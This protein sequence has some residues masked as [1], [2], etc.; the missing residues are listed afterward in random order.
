[1]AVSLTSI[2]QLP[3]LQFNYDFE[4]FF[5]KNDP[6][7]LAYQ[8]HIAEFGHD[9]DYLLIAVEH[10]NGIFNPSFL[11]KA[12][13]MIRHISALE[14]VTQILSPLSAQ[15]IIQS[16]LGT[17]LV[18]YLHKDDRNRLIQDSLQLSS[19]PNLAEKLI[20]SEIGALA[21][22]VYHERY[23]DKT[24]EAE[25]SEAI[26]QVVGDF[27]FSNFHVAGRIQA[28]SIFVQLI[29]ENF[30]TFLTISI[31]LIIS[32]LFLLFGHLKWVIIP[33]VMIGLSIAISLSVL[34]I[35]N[36][37]VDILSSMLPTILLVTAMS[38]ITHF[39]TRYFDL[40]AR[41]HDKLEA[42]RLTLKEVGMATFLTSITTAIGFASLVITDS[43]PVRNLGIYTSIG[44]MITYAV[45]FSLLS[46]TATLSRAPKP[47]TYYPI[48]NYVLGKFFLVTLRHSKQVLV[49]YG[50]LTLIAFAGLKLLVVDTPLIAD[51]PRDHPVTYDFAFFD[52]HFGGSKPLEVS[53]TVN[54]P[55]QDML[56]PD[57]IKAV[58]KV[59]SYL[60]VPFPNIISPADMVKTLNM[61]NH[62]GQANYYHL[63]DSQDEAKIAR[64]FPQ[65][66]HHFPIMLI[67]DDQQGGRI[68]GFGQDLGSKAGLKNQQDF[69]QYVSSNIN[70]DL[71][72][73][74]FT[75]T[76][77]LF[78]LTTEA[79][80]ENIIF[81]LA[82][83]MAVVALIMSLLFRSLKMILI[84][85]LPNILPLL[86]LAA[87]M[88]FFGIPLRLSTSIIF[89]IAFGIAV[90]DTIHFLTRFNLEM[91]RAHDHTKH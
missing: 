33:L 5:E 72:G 48:W 55:E 91:K 3:G 63:P 30:S 79:L 11:H 87:V 17:V 36:Q 21:F 73:F 35:A 69:E 53:I 31:V 49:V 20:N 58:D 65:L 61:A 85:L 24:L 14:G 13:S 38:D 60:G 16:P 25:L 26:S 23:N 8:D 18:P 74:K 39:L 15:K 88:A 6:D 86:F 70:N 27:A 52:Q 12:D 59:T 81:G 7:W 37:A 68:T 44:V 54:D 41:G 32:I 62:G 83:A 43:I 56:S 29:R 50:I 46:A 64:Q 34:V 10:S 1:M 28:Q 42:V 9:N 40:T 77:Y 57:V 67:T 19:H 71:I 2:L 89:A 66:A 47:S 82:L 90:D 78:D 22:I 80:V 84:A 51:F 76:S 75:G 45:T 4:N